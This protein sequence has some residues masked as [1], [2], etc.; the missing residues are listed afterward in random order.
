MA[1]CHE[2]KTKLVE[3]GGVVGHKLGCKSKLPVRV[4]GDLNSTGHSLPFF[5]L[6]RAQVVEERGPG[7]SRKGRG[8]GAGSSKDE[9][10]PMF[11]MS[12][13]CWT[14]RICPEPVAYDI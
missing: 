8:E 11:V 13:R 3:K 1:N 2:E 10:D 12:M 5:A 4:P 9:V 14:K 6:Q 7:Q